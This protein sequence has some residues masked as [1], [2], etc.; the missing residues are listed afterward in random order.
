[1][2]SLFT[3]PLYGCFCKEAT[4]KKIETVSKQADSLTHKYNKLLNCRTASYRCYL[5]ALQDEFS[6]FLDGEG[7]D[8][9]VVEITKTISK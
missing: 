2:K 9:S 4:N 1:M 3:L 8:N 6:N 7:V 5:K